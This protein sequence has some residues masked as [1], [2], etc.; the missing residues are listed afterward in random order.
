MTFF[1]FV[2]KW[3]QV[4]PEIQH[5]PGHSSPNPRFFLTTGFAS[6]MDFMQNQ[7]LKSSPCVVMESGAPMTGSSNGWIY[8]DYTIYFCVRDPQLTNAGDGRAAKN[9]KL[10]AKQLAL[11]F[12]NNALAMNSIWRQKGISMSVE[13]DWN[14]EDYGPFW[15]WWYAAELHIRVGEAAD[16]CI[17]QELMKEL[18]GCGCHKP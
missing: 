17:G 12:K 15:T 10:E 5:V 2:E 16:T 9:C 11:A 6:M 3:A 14:I 13:N 7:G 4:H 8:S 1:D 18:M